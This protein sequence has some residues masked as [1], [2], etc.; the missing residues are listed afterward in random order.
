MGTVEGRQM[1][2]AAR[3][4][5]QNGGERVKEEEE[6]RGAG[7]AEATWRKG[8]LWK[9]EIRERGIARA[10]GRRRWHRQGG[11]GE[12]KEVDLALGDKTEL[13]W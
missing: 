11:E 10:G 6:E 5:L 13:G 7:G 1:M 3:P 8:D 2:S 4:R 9:E 12:C